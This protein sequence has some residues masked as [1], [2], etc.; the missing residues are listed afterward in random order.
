M[1]VNVLKLGVG[2]N[3]GLI[4]PMILRNMPIPTRKSR[5]FTFTTTAAAATPNH[6]HEQTTGIEV[7]LFE[8]DRAL[9]ADKHNHLLGVVKLPDSV[10]PLS[11][12]DPKPV[13][14]RSSASVAVGSTSLNIQVELVLDDHNLKATVRNIETG[15]EK[16]ILIPTKN[17]WGFNE[18]IEMV[19]HLIADAE[20]NRAQD[21]VLRE[22]SGF[23]KELPGRVLGVEDRYQWVFHEL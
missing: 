20:A 3:N 4:E 15:Y 19:G 11:D 18:D 9:A 12:L 21:D 7:R 23:T 16:M 17:L 5:T 6:N 1:D 10:T 22:L 2:L 8:G 14:T 13:T